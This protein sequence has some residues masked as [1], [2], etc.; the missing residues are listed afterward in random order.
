MELVVSM[1]IGSIL[2][3]LLASILSSATK[4]WR[5][6]HNYFDVNDEARSALQV[7]TS[8]LKSAILRNFPD[9]AEGLRLMRFPETEGSE[10]AK[11]K[12]ADWLMFFTD[13]RDHGVDDPAATSAVSYRLVY[14]DV[15]QE[16]GEYPQ[17]LL[18]RTLVQSRTSFEEI[19][20]KPSLTEAYWTKEKATPLGDVLASNI[21]DFRITPRL[22]NSTGAIIRVPVHLPIRMKGRTIEIAGEHDLPIDADTKLHSF[23]LSVAVLNTEGL[24]RLETGQPMEDAI[25][26]NGRRFTQIVALP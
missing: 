14:R 13:A 5:S 20:N 3:V 21:V 15:L 22:I 6:A 26:T 8:D 25:K 24:V 16:N 12:N 2:I 23:E 17:F 18:Y 7:L 19:I 11:A 4:T 10:E 1:A 9:D